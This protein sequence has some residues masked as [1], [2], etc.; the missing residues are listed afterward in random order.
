[1]L[2][3]RIQ[4]VIAC[5]IDKSDTVANSEKDYK[6]G[7]ELFPSAGTVRCCLDL[8]LVTFWCLI[9]HNIILCKCSDGCLHVIH[10]V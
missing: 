4:T 2:E 6:L 1:M 8:M 9:L 5:H 10:G 3:V 7:D